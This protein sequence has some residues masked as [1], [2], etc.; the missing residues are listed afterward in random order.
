[1]FDP[2]NEHKSHIRAALHAQLV[3]IGVSVCELLGIHVQGI[4]LE[5]PEASEHLITPGGAASHLA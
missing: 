1:M 4:S 2:A 5:S 3:T